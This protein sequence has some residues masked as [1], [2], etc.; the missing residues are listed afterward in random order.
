MGAISKALGNA[1]D[2][3]NKPID[4]RITFLNLVKNGTSP[5]SIAREIA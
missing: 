2:V 1:K 4:E 3:A 5:S